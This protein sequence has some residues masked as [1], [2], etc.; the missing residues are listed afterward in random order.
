MNI[1][2]TTF[3]FKNYFLKDDTNNLLK[4][5]ILILLII[6]VY[7]SLNYIKRSIIDTKDLYSVWGI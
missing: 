6:F 2:L 1:I 5:G 4:I 7:F 3:M